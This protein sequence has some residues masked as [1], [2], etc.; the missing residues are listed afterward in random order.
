MAVLLG[1]SILVK[2]HELYLLRV[3]KGSLLMQIAR[4]LVEKPIYSCLKKTRMAYDRLR[5]L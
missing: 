2:V 3:R 4:V 1:I 5:V